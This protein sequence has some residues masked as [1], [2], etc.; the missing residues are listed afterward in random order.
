MPDALL[1]LDP[2]AGPVVRDALRDAVARALPGWRLAVPGRRRGAAALA[3]RARAADAL[4]VAG[5]TLGTELEGG[6]RLAVLA[7]RVHDRPVALVDVRAPDGAASGAARRRARA[8]VRAADLL[9]V[10]GRWTAARL[11]AAGAPPPFRVGGPLLWAAAPLRVEQDAGAAPRA[12]LVAPRAP[13]SARRLA[14]ALGA[15]ARHVGLPVV[16]AQ[17]RTR[18]APGPDAAL[19]RA[20][21]ARLPDAD[22]LAPVPDVGAARAQAAAAGVVL[23]QTTTDAV[24]ALGAGARVAVQSADPDLVALAAAAGQ[25]V[26]GP[27]ATPDDLVAAVAGAA[28]GA[29]APDSVAAAQAEAA[30]GTLGLLRL[31]CERGRTPGAL[32][33]PTLPLEPPPE[34]VA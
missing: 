10:R 18:R 33:T 24:L 12:L 4:V 34:V 6:V 16:L 15:A 7:A 25:P 5:G 14:R 31:V 23:A 21:A 32:T 26:T 19:L 27:A 22:V 3:R 28:A 17:W 20:V 1:C 29:P 11:A 30:E 8:L 13:A 2:L 9:V